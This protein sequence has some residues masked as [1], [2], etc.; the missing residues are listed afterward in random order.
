MTVAFV[1]FAV[2]VVSIDYNAWQ[3]FHLDRST[4]KYRPTVMPGNSFWLVTEIDHYKT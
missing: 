1:Y 3:Y 2:Q 4:L